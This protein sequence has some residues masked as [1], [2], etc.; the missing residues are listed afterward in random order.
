MDLILGWVVA[1]M[2]C[3]KINIKEKQASGIQRTEHSSLVG[4]INGP[5]GLIYLLRSC[6]A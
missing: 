3:V 6:K 5:R 2:W 1:E 4:L